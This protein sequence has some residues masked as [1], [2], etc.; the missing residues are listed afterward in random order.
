MQDVL[1]KATSQE[2]V[3]LK[4]LLEEGGRQEDRRIEGR[5]MRDGR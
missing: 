3:L 4:F 2:T 5:R 1:Y